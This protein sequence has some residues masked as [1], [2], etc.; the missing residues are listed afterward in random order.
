MLLKKNIFY[1]FIVLSLALSCKKG[2]DGDR[3]LVDN[4]ETIMIVDSV[5][6]SGDTRLTTRISVHWWGVSNG[7]F[8][9]AYEVSI[10]SMNT[11]TYTTSQDST[12]LMQIPAGNDSA[13]L[14]VYV[15][16][17]DNF[18]QKDLTPAYT[19]FPIK[20]SPPTVQFLFS[21]PVAGIPSQNP[22]I[23]F[24]VIKYN[25]LAD[26]PDG[27]NDILQYE[28]FI[29]DTLSIPYIING[30]SS[31]FTFVGQNFIGTQTDCKVYLGTSN[32]P[33][34]DKIDGM[35]LNDNNIVYIRAVDKALS[36]SKY[37]AAPEIF[38]KKPTSKTLM[39]NAYNSNKIFVQNFYANTMTSIGITSFDTLQ[40][41]EL[42]NNNYTQLAPD[43]QTQSRTFELFDKIVWFSDDASFSLSL[44]QRSTS[45]F[46]N[47]GGRMFMVLALS[48]S[49][50]PLS[51]FLD[52][53]PVKSLV[54][55]PAGSILRVNVNAPVK[56]IKSDWPVLKSTAII[57]SVRPF[58]V[59][60]S[61]AG[62]YAFDSLLTAEI[63]ESK[64]GLP[65]EIWKGTSTVLGRRYNVNT[66][67]S[68]F[69]FS[70]IP[71]ERFNGNNNV[72]SLF[73]KV[74]ISELE[75]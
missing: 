15:R 59:P 29:N 50:D 12:I 43:Y 54:D 2:Y 25:F 74:M 71:F 40:A 13:D 75:F 30:S 7:G 49:F 39:I 17:I 41:S 28:L 1:F 20:N 34:T 33:L 60:I 70:S 21:V 46:F 68:N 56:P 63:T 67:K 66:L 16:A 44:G 61:G 11:W 27:L 65:P 37:I 51:N 45:N 9:S 8:I 69:I 36:K 6:R 32:N 62:S 14:V 4:P 58:L 3:K 31:S 47:K 35:K 57:P 24:P 22:K 53:T 26:D 23:S 18:G 55:P 52:W 38:I 42:I 10:D 5:H 48:S 73:R 64:T 72:D 19:V